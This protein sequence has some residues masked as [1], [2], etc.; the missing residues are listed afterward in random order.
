MF[1]T[2]P[3]HCTQEPLVDTYSSVVQLR[4]TCLGEF[5]V[6]G[7]SAHK[8]IGGEIQ[9]VHF[10][11][12]SD[13]RN[14]RT[15]VL[16][17]R[18]FRKRGVEQLGCTK[19]PHSPPHT[20]G[21]P[22]EPRGFHVN[23]SNGDFNRTTHHHSGIPNERTVGK[24]GREICRT[25]TCVRGS[26]SSASRGEHRTSVLMEGGTWVRARIELRVQQHASKHS[27]SV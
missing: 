8:A 26:E 16:A 5:H 11:N 12:G 23:P 24:G 25:A 7:F 6:F 2:L 17:R 19:Y 10:R 18:V 22:R 15:T 13:D 21:V 3:E 9:T 4:C 14:G 20:C 1:P 27:F